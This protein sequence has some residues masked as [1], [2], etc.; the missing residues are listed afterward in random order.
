MKRNMDET[1]ILN[2]KK[3][4]SIISKKKSHSMV[5]YASNFIT[6]KE[7][8]IVSRA[9]YPIKLISDLFSLKRYHVVKNIFFCDES[10]KI[11]M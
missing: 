1:L 6:H 3:S 5:R 10:S 11:L 7:L 8:V 4:H 2:K 9:F